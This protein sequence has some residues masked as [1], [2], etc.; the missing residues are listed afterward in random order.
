MYSWEAKRIISNYKE[1]DEITLLADSVRINGILI[2]YDDD[3]IK[4][5]SDDYDEIITLTYEDIE[6]I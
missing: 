1:G 5:K 6:D 3:Y 2:N 4:I